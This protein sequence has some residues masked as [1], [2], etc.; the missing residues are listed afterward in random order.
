MRRMVSLG[1]SCT[2]HWHINRLGLGFP[3]RLPFDLS[4]TPH[5]DLVRFLITDFADVWPAGQVE[6]S[7]GNHGF[8]LSHIP[9]VQVQGAI[10]SWERRV[11]RFREL[12]RE[13]LHFVRS[14][15]G[16]GV[17]VPPRKAEVADALRR[18]GFTDF[19]LQYV[20]PETKPEGAPWY[21]TDAYWND[22]L[23]RDRGNDEKTPV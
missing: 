11:A 13:P 15:H 19:T 6:L 3:E 5:A 16:R 10:K 7:H 22:V 9:L 23:A 12:R 4:I 14:V 8:R 21:G 2:P 18:F 17:D 1:A 20:P